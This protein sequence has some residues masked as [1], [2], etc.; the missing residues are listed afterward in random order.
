MGEVY[1]AVDPDLGREV[2]LKILP[3]L[4]RDEERGARF[5]REARA[6]ASF[7]HPNVVTIYSVEDADGLDFLTM[8]L[9]DGATLSEVVPDDGLSL[10]GFFE[11]AHG[12]VSGIAE[13]HR[14]GIVHR[15]LKPSNVMVSVAGVAKVLDFGLA[16]LG[17]EHPES[18]EGGWKTRSGGFLGTPAYASPEQ[19][20]GRGADSRSDVFALGAVLYWML[21]GRGPFDADSLPGV[22]AAVMRDDPEPLASVRPDVPRE[23]AE[24]VSRCLSKSVDERYASAVE[25]Q[26]ALDEARASLDDPS[27]QRVG[28]R[29]ALV[30]GAGAL[31]LLIVAS[32]WEADRRETS[33][34]RSDELPRIEKLLTDQ[35]FATA[36]V[37]ARGA[38]ESLP[39]DPYV[40]DLFDRSSMPVEVKIEPDGSAVAVKGYADPESEWIELGES[41]LGTV[42]LPAGELRWRATKAGYVPLEGHVD[43]WFGELSGE[44][45]A[46]GEG[47]SNAVRVPAGSHSEGAS[48]LEVPAYWID[49]HEVTNREFG[50][51]VEAGG[52]L[53]RQSWPL[54]VEVD[55]DPLDGS[56]ADLLFVDR[57]GR[58]GPSTWSYGT[59]PEGGADLPVT[60]V[61]WYE[62]SAYCSFVGAELPTIYHWRRAAFP[63]VYSR[64]LTLSNFGSDGPADVGTFPGLGPFGTYDMAGNAQEWTS[65]ANGSERY[66]LGGGWDQPEYLFEGERSRAPSTRE[67]SFGFRCMRPIGDVPELLRAER[68]P[69]EAGLG[70]FEPIDDAR[71]ALLEDQYRYDE[72]PFA[73]RA[74][75][76]E[77]S[78]PHWRVESLS[79]AGVRPG[80]EILLRLLV[81]RSAEPPYQAVLYFPGSAAM[82]T[83]SV[84]APAELAFA[85]FIPRSGR[86]LVYP[87]YAGMY[88]RSS[89]G[90]VMIATRGDEPVSATTAFRDLRVEWGREVRRVV[91]Y[92][93][94]REDIDLDRLGF[95]G[96]SLGAFYGPIYAAIEGRFDAVVWMGGGASAATL[97]H[98]PP[99]IQPAHFAPRVRVPVLMIGGRSD[100]L[101]PVES[102]QRP[103]LDLLGT[104]GE[105][106]R[107]A[108]LDGGHIP[109]WEG[110]I[111]ES[112]DWFDRYL[113]P[114]D[115]ADRDRPPP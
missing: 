25:L 5:R 28:R 13:A 6:L 113:G 112:L 85:E 8:E 101:A 63:G 16:K 93:A 4:D 19:V 106:K 24:V 81:P 83:P 12:L 22:L 88:E 67:Q 46:I 94:T 45:V 102:S 110:V 69:P 100:S 53:D 72:T 27:T 70:D 23:L 15:D 89:A 97:D 50:A 52:Y 38:L 17:G 90:S 103:L 42:D 109:P 34:V 43:S 91:D 51:F 82:V 18:A 58:A 71:F 55:G 10:D 1:R 99:E 105:H 74:W 29:R 41:P 61:S 33:R 108:I 26:Q 77:D 36:F 104:P 73:A 11:L 39:D 76:S 57:T 2:A 31:V 37:A 60:G 35:R 40:R 59:Y 84:R 115:R 47:P 21:A 92:L 68:L 98:Y 64:V 44:L 111:R 7:S 66:I 65:T 107:L 14:R 20:E 114:V 56:E 62:A 54:S 3:D 49:R 30:V 78:N 86:V 75:A 32:F 96:L 87:A 48:S 9:V 80:E 79:I 95:F